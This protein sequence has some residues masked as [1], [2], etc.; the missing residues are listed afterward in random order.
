[1]RRFDLYTPRVAA[2]LEATAATLRDALEVSFFEHESGF[3]GGD[4]FVADVGDVTIIVKANHVDEDGYPDE[5]D[6][7]DAILVYLEGPPRTLQAMT[8]A[9]GEHLRHRRTETLAR[10]VPRSPR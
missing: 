5:P 6:F 8:G 4:Y 9:L 3:L 2:S 1:V 10:R 7:P